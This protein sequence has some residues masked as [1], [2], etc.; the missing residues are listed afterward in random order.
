MVFEL[1]KTFICYLFIR[2]TYTFGSFTKRITEIYKINIMALTSLGL[3][4]IF[5]CKISLVKWHLIINFRNEK[6]YAQV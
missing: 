1:S 4:K 3:L 6:K 5:N 2:V